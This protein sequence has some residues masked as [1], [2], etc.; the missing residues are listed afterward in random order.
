MWCEIQT[1]ESLLGQVTTS[2]EQCFRNTFVFILMQTDQ[3]NHLLFTPCDFTVLYF[4]KMGQVLGDV[5]SPG[6]FR[7]IG[8][9][10]NSEDFQREFRL[11]A[12]CQPQY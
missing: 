3:I 1:P 10:G 5:H 7:V 9:L 12:G 8:P 4:G 2:G 6:K 11:V